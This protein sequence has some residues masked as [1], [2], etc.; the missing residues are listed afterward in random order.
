MTLKFKEEPI[1]MAQYLRSEKD[2]YEPVRLN[3]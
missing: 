1:K 3:R 2:N